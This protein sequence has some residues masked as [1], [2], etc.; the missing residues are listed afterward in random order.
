MS[1]IENG[2]DNLNARTH[3]EELLMGFQIANN[4]NLDELEMRK[5][6]CETF[7]KMVED[8]LPV[9]HLDADCMTGIGI[10]P[11]RN[12]YPNNIIACGVSEANMISVAA[13][14]SREGKIPFAHSLASFASRRPYDQIYVSGAYAKCNIKIISTDSGINA[15]FNGGTHAPIEDIAIMR[16]IPGMTI[17]E[18]TDSVMLRDLLYKAVSNYGMYYF[19]LTRRKLTKIYEEG[20]TF[21]IGGSATI[22][23][24]EDITVFTS[25]FLVA[26]L[27]RLAEMLL[28][29][30]ISVRVVD[31]YCLKPI[32]TACIIKAAEET[33][34]VVTVENHNIIGGLG[35]AI[36]EVLVQNKPIPMEMVGIQD[37]FLFSASPTWLMEN[38]GLTNENII[39]SIRKTLSR[40]RDS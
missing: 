30:G 32:D 23:E 24:G 4:F 12:K 20:S 25:G 21:S 16:A 40:K 28:K 19:R 6:Y 14:M 39:T 27:I 22:R 7:I 18:P 34:A 36:A 33:G 10:L 5:V 31:I 13:G 26:E 15:G 35:S 2:F 9:M 29:E 3:H 17:L 37:R 8:G 1:F 11:Y 38:Y